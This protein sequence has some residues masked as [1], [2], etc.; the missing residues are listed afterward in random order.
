[1]RSW[2]T[3][4][5]NPQRFC[6]CDRYKPAYSV[7][8]R[9]RNASLRWGWVATNALTLTIGCREQPR[10]EP[11]ADRN[12]ISRRYLAES[13]EWPTAVFVGCSGVLIHSRIVLT[14]AHCLVSAPGPS[15]EAL[16]GEDTRLPTRRISIERCLSHPRF[17]PP[18]SDFDIGF[19][20][21]ASAVPERVVKESSFANIQSIHVGQSVRVVGF[22][23]QRQPGKLKPKAPTKSWFETTVAEPSGAF[24]TLLRAVGTS[25]CDGDSGGPVYIQT[26]TD[27]WALLGLV[28][29]AVGAPCESPTRIVFVSPHLPWIEQESGYAIRAS[30]ESLESDASVSRFSND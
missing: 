30:G 23:S 12:A 15:T 26:G 19:C 16:F 2:C 4:K 8:H 17:R 20:I 14:A 5:E 24:T 18:L 7:L 25:S 28:S 6:W 11:P 10:S 3:M 27:H 29:A 13:G 9:V 21:L 1:M 22:A